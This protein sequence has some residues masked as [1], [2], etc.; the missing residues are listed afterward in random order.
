ME[1]AVDWYH[2]RLLTGPTPG[3]R[4]A[5]CA[6]GAST[7][8]MVGQFRIG[9]APDD[10]G[11]AVQGAARCPTDV[12][13]DTGLGFVNRGDRQQDFF[14]ARVLFPI[15]D[16]QRRAGGVRGP[17]AARRRGPEV[18]ELAGDA[19][20]TRRARCSTPSTGRRRTSCSD[21]EVVVC[22]GYTD[23]IGFFRAGVPARRRHLR[24]G[25]HRGARPA[26]EAVRPA[27]RAGLRRRRRRARPRPSAFYEWEQQA[28]DRGGGAPTCRRAPTRPTSPAPTR[29]RCGGGRRGRARSSGSASTACSA[30]PTSRTPEGRARAA[31]AAIDVDPR[32]PER[33]WCATST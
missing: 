13:D 1:Q 19:R 4:A 26:A 7:A 18:P 20:S 23:V 22:E 32:A 8:T 27:A 25:A 30:A 10:V 21:D 28:R 16:D 11:R 12:A 29:A 3:G 31:E 9:W 17:Q 24:H 15:F 6:A 33:R 5:T 14:R 2:E